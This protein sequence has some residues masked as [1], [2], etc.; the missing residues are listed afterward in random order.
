MLT[1]IVTVALGAAA[2]AGELAYARWS[3][4]A[5]YRTGDTF[6]NLA[7]A[8]FE[9]LFTVLVAAP[10][11]ALYTFAWERRV[12]ATA[13]PMWI[14]LPVAL[15]LMDFGFYWWHRASHRVAILWFG[16]AVHHSSEE[17]NF[18]VAARASGWQKLTQRFFYLPI[19]LAGVPLSTMLI[20]D[21]VT[22]LYAQFLHSRVVPKLGWL[23]TIL[24][25]PSQH[26][27]HH[28]R[29]PEYLD[30][31]FGAM[32]ALWD[33]LFGTF[34]EERA[35][36]IFGLTTPLETH[37]VAWARFHVLFEI[38]DRMKRARGL[39]A[40][41][42]APFRPPEWDPDVRF[43]P[44]M[45]AAPPR[46]LQ[47]TASPRLRAYVYVQY[48]ILFVA[49][50]AFT[51]VEWSFPAR[52]VAALWLAASLAAVGALLDR[53]GQRAG[54]HASVRPRSQERFFSAAARAASRGTPRPSS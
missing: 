4:R 6:T 53:P 45:P 26:R 25:T 19:A 32:F 40:K 46:P 48:T 11:Y 14:G 17:F 24:V 41:L 7:A 49:V 42:L 31:N 5:L 28:A 52:L 44:S 2:I 22:T 29:N 8:G 3:G 39:A 1:L 35:E 43:D 10:V 34:A 36:P 27:V 33:R 13:L 12:V 20:A 51:F 15:V 47:T 37:N 38:A 23:E 30:K 16:H 54:M 9:H 18:S 50:F 21:A